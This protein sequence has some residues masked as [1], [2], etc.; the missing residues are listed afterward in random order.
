V[1][2]ALFIC[3]SVAVHA[4][5]LAMLRRERPVRPIEIVIESGTLKTQSVPQ[6]RRQTETQTASQTKTRTRAMTAAAST[7]Q[8]RIGP[9]ASKSV[10]E[11]PFVGGSVREDVGGRVNGG[12]IELFPEGTLRAQAGV[13]APNWGGRTRRSGDGTDR[14]PS[15]DEARTVTRRVGQWMAEIGDEERARANVPPEW[16]DVERLIDGG[17]HPAPAVVTDDSRAKTLAKQLVRAQP[18]SGPTAR[19]FDPSLDADRRSS[20]FREAQIAACQQAYAQPA[21]WHRTE[22][23]VVVGAD[24]TL[25]SARVAASSGRAPLD[26]AALEAVRRAV[27]RRPIRDV[28]RG[29]APDCAVEVRWAVEASARVEPPTVTPLVDPITNKVQGATVALFGLSFDESSGHVAFNYPFRRDVRTR[30][31][32]IAIGAPTVTSPDTRAPQ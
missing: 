32:L 23:A 13:A 18:S 24:G 29:R 15:G 19:T 10:N 17:F 6:S 4:G 27:E 26:R 22:I 14:E 28:C 2:G 5:V 7:A 11:K 25:R 9:R 12:S 16:R 8:T 30:V 31:S 21:D 20:Q 3:V 1:R